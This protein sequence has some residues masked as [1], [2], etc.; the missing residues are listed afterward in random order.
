M[1]RRSLAALAPDPSPASKGGRGEG[2][3]GAISILNLARYVNPIAAKAGVHP[4]ACS[5]EG[6]TPAFAGVSG[7]WGYLW[8]GMAAAMCAYDSGLRRMSG[9]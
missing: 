7:G 4:D 9:F 3:G 6:W 8:A 2:A 5:V 1:R